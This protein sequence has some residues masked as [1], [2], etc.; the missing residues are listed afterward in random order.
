MLSYVS[1]E[2]I[3]LKRIFQ[4]T[5]SKLLQNAINFAKLIVVQHI[6]KKY[7]LVTSS[8]SGNKMH[9]QSLVN[10]SPQEQ[11]MTMKHKK[12]KYNDYKMI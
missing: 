11:K 5:Q 12:A 9:E 4:Y 1:K 10:F 7:S 2:Y 8:S 3:T 6:C